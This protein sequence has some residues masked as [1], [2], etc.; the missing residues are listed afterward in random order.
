MQFEFYFF[1]NGAGG[2]WETGNQFGVLV[3]VSNTC[4]IDEYIIRVLVSTVTAP[5]CGT[6][7]GFVFVAR[8]P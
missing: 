4:T 6:V 2:G 8:I 7:T 5:L 1:L 3:T